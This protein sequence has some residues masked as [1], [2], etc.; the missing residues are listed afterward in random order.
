[1]GRCELSKWVGGCIDEGV[2]AFAVLR[3][4]N[5]GVSVDVCGGL[6]IGASDLEVE[7]GERG[8]EGGEVG[9]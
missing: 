2:D 5:V 4:I 1:M 9:V 7:F 3:S 8:I 6:R